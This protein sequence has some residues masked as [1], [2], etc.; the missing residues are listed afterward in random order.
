M[1]IGSAHFRSPAEIV[2]YLKVAL[3]WE[4]LYFFGYETKSYS[5]NILKFASFWRGQFQTKPLIIKP[6]NKQ[7]LKFEIR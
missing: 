2:T 4:K 6:L 1:F 5:H 7:T 3:T